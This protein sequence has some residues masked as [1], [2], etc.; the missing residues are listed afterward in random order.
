MEVDFASLYSADMIAEVSEDELQQA[1]AAFPCCSVDESGLTRGEPFNVVIVGT[2]TALRRAFLRTDWRETRT[3][4]PE[5]E[6]ARRHHYRGR[7]PDGT[8]FQARPDGRER[9]ELRLWLTPVVAE[10]LPVWLGQ[11]VYDLSPGKAQ[12]V[13]IIDPDVDLARLFLLQELWY[14]QSLSRFAYV[15]GA[16]AAGSKEPLRTLGGGTFFSDGLRAILWLSEQPVGL[17]E[18][19]S[20][21]W[22]QPPRRRKL[23][24]AR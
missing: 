12:N 4:S 1:F 11:V 2:G 22:E 17:D 13:E 15:S 19:E 6:L 23:S 5:F 10:G 16:P 9:K 21:S 3:D 14:S 24:Q 8:F 18:V 20:L 7:R